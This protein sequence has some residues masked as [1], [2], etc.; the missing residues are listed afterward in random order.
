MVGAS[1]IVI[2]VN[3]AHQNVLIYAHIL[4]ISEG[5]LNVSLIVHFGLFQSVDGMDRTKHG[6]TSSK[7]TS[8]SVLP[9]E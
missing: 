9:L 8:V 7:E 5:F 6:S 3:L 1:P 2:C 4:D